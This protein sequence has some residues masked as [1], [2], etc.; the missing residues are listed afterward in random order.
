M[1]RRVLLI[2]LAL[3]VVVNAGGCA[4]NC[5]CTSSQSEETKSQAKETNEQLHKE[6]ERKMKFL[7]YYVASQYVK[8]EAEEP[9]R[10][11]AVE[12]AKK[13]PEEYKWY[14]DWGMES[15]YFDK[16]IRKC[17]GD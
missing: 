9:C 5:C 8:A 14:K 15:F 2:V 17:M 12:K 13:H 7:A 6:Y 1:F 16:E 4:C 10:K 11:K 3:V